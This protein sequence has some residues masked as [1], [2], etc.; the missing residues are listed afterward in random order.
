[1]TEPFITLWDSFG[2]YFSKFHD[3]QREY[4]KILN[5]FKLLLSRSALKTLALHPIKE[6]EI[7]D[8]KNKSAE[9]ID[10]IILYL[11]KQNQCVK[12]L[13]DF[14]KNKPEE[15]PKGYEIDFKTLDEAISVNKSFKKELED[16]KRNINKKL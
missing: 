6:G 8:F 3:H 16:F 5:D 4:L 2:F 7:F 10:E 12:D 14:I 9:K 1:M 13:K 15:I 11:N